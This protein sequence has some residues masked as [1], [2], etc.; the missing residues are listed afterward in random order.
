MEDRWLSVKEIATYLGIKRDTIYKWLEKKNLPAHKV[1][2]LWKF[3]KNEIDE[4]I[5]SG[6]SDER[7]T[8]KN[9]T[10]KK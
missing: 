8:K 5:Q 1:G 7:A 10:S 9:K 2:G 3:K 4:W 6:E